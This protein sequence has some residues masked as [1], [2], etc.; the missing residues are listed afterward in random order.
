MGQRLFLLLVP[1]GLENSHMKD[2]QFTRDY[3]PRL[4]ALPK[5]HALVTKS[6]VAA[7]AAVSIRTVENWM[8][9]RRIPFIRLGDRCV[10]FYLPS[11]LVALSKFEIKDVGPSS[12]PTRDATNLLA[13]PY[14]VANEFTGRAVAAH[15]GE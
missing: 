8:R 4:D 12:R 9:Q 13:K 15:S 10:R 3:E 11:V 5:S 6:D 14:T 1:T 2:N 7:A